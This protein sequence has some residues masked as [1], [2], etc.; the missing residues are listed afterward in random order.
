MCRHSVSEIEVDI[1]IIIILILFI[2]V[3]M[4]VSAAAIILG[5]LS[6]FAVARIVAGWSCGR[7]RS[8]WLA[9]RR[10]LCGLVVIVA[11][12]IIRYCV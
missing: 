6:W 2:V 8:Y 7:W 12:F 11:V 1:I 3:Y 4:V 10:R 9:L 5:R